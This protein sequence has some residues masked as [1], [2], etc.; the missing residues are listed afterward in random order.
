[1]RNINDLNSNLQ[2]IENMMGGN[3]KPEGKPANVRNE[4]Q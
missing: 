3:R 2:N 4:E 1:M